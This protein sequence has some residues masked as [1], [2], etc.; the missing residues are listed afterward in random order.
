MISLPSLKHLRPAVL[1][2]AFSLALLLFAAP[3][4]KPGPAP[5]A[6]QSQPGSQWKSYHDP[7]VPFEFSYPDDLVLDAHV[8]PKLGFIFALMKKVDSPKYDWL[9]DVD[10][11]DRAD[12]D[13]PPYSAMSFQEFA[14]IRARAGCDADGP[15]GSVSCPALVRSAPFTNRSGLEGIEFYLKQV[16]ERYNPP[17][18]TQSVV[19]PIYSLRLPVGKFDKALAFKFTDRGQDVH[20]SNELL[21]QIAASVSLAR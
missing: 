14:V 6:E 11:Q 4:A 1:F 21:K 12:F 3:P 20:L 9:I 10:Y 16:D 15:D 19:G 13:G 17:K 8:N 5:Q 2:L 18:T 7:Q